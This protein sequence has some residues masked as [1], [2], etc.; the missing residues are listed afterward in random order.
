[1]LVGLRLQFG[2]TFLYTGPI[3]KKKNCLKYCFRSITINEI[4]TI[5]IFNEIEFFKELLIRFILIN[6]SA[7]AGSK[8]RCGGERVRRSSSSVATSSRQRSSAV[9]VLE[10][11]H[12]DREYQLV[13]ARL[14]LHAT[15]A[16]PAALPTSLGELSAG[17]CGSYFIRADSCFQMTFG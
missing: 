6:L 11:H 14:Q 3:E 1:M 8:R 16:A 13:H 4:V 12:I 17:Q 5:F 9:K 7:G 10:L 15:S 2:N